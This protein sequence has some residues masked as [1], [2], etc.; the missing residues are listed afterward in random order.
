VWHGYNGLDSELHV[1]LLL[2]LLNIDRLQPSL[3][4]AASPIEVCTVEGV[5]SSFG[6]PA[7]AS[8][9]LDSIVAAV[10]EF[11]R[12]NSQGSAEVNNFYGERPKSVA[13][14]FIPAL[15]SVFNG[16]CNDACGLGSAETP[17]FLFA[18]FVL[19][20][21]HIVRN[22]RIALTVGFQPCAGNVDMALKLRTICDTVLSVESFAGRAHTVP[23][24]FKDFQGFLVLHKIQQYGTVA[25]FRPPGTRFGL[26]RDRRKLHIESLH[27]PPE[28]SRAFS[29][30]GGAAPAPAPTPAAVATAAAALSSGLAAL[31]VDPTSS[32]ADHGHN[33]SHNHSHGAHSATASETA[34]SSRS[35]S[36][37]YSASGSATTPAT[38]PAAAAATATALPV[39]LTPLQASLAALKAARMS[40]SV[41]ASA[42]APATAATDAPLSL[43][44]SLTPVSIHRPLSSIG[45]TT[46]ASTSTSTSTRAAA[47]AGT[48]GATLAPVP[49]PAPAPVLAQVSTVAGG[50]SSAPAPVT[51]AQPP[52]QPGQ[53]CGAG[54]PG[55]SSGA[56]GGSN[57]YDF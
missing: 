34:G 1:C 8:G 54:L 43:G 30:T 29:T 6:I 37:Q 33:H 24:E 48:L 36:T 2:F 35:S 32:S 15:H 38:T 18:R 47:V 44:A 27:L 20:L 42:L 39:V 46:S 12:K 49:A 28:E 26:K 16:V 19:R 21:K 7:T 31:S 40:A 55:R 14:V 23:Y 22:G 25:P 10:G 41:S 57:V 56:A 52:L 13:R 17:L 51:P 5:V 45:G 53:A 50:G 11:A 3:V 4:N 9:I